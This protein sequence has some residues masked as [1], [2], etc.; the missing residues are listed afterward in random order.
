MAKD[1]LR[2][3]CLTLRSSLKYTCVRDE[4]ERRGEL[5]AAGAGAKLQFVVGAK[6]KLTHKTEMDLALGLSWTLEYGLRIS[7]SSSSEARRL[8]SSAET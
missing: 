1:T 7:N 6:L 8:G 2:T 4:R 5:G 3:G